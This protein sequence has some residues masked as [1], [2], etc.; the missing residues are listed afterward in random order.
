VNRRPKVALV[1]AG[2]LLAFPLAACGGGS[3]EPDG[4]DGEATPTAPPTDDDDT[5]PDDDA[6][7]EADSEDDDSDKGADGSGE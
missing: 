4:N 3:V 1:L 2:A 5:Q 6:G 7:S